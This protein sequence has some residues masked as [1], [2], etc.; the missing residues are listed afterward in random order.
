[1]IRDAVRRPGT[2]AA[3]STTGFVSLIVATM[4]D[5]STGGGVSVVADVTLALAA[6]V[7]GGLWFDL[8][9]DQEVDA[10]QSVRR[11]LAL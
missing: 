11:L 9:R 4:I 5:S 7:L 8:P 6:A 10:A 1:M 2:I 3:V